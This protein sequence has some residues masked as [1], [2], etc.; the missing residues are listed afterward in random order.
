MPDDQE[1]NIIPTP[2]TR[3]PAR[4]AARFF[5]VVEVVGAFALVHVTYRAIKHFTTIGRWGSAAGTNF[6]PG[7]VMILFTMGMVWACRRDCRFYGLTLDRWRQWLSIGVTCAMVEAAFGAV[8]LLLSGFPLDAS[9]PPDPHAPPPWKEA[10][11]FVAF[12]FTGCV[13]ALA[14]VGSRKQ[15]ARRMPAALSIALVCALGSVPGLISVYTH[16]PFSALMALWLFVGAGIGEELFYRGYIQSRVDEVWG[17]PKRVLGFDVGA[18]LVVSSLLFGLVHGLNT[19]DY[20]HDRFDFNWRM[21]ISS[22][23]GGAYFSLIRSRT[24]SVW[25][26]AVLHGLTDILARVPNVL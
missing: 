8:G 22:V 21:G 17:Q 1:T 6:T 9:R 7:V 12:L 19:V 23:F 5:A 15:V 26:G 14:M 11:I 2:E 25:P 4:P 20:F 16:K 10:G 18:G 13:I 24:G 3:G